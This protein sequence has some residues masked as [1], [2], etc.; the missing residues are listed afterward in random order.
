VARTRRIRGIDQLRSDWDELARQDAFHAI[1][2]DPARV[3]GGWDQDEF[4]AHGRAA[5]A[6]LYEI[7]DENDVKLGDSRA[8][9]FGCGAG[10]LSFALAER[11]AAVTGVD[12]SEGMLARARSVGIPSNCEL[13]LQTDSALPGIDRG[14]YDLVISLLVLQHMRPRVAR[15]YLRTLPDLLAPGGVLF[16]Q[17]PHGY[18]RTTDRDARSAGRAMARRLLPQSAIDLRRWLAL[19]RSAARRRRANVPTFELHRIRI[20]TVRRILGRAGLDA[21]VL[22]RDDPGT[23][24]P[25]S[26][27]WY[28]AQRAHA[29]VT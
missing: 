13:V 7:L 4:Y 22:T 1:L 25:L 26:S 5:V 6:R 24:A 15:A 3:D 10:R 19:R 12:V 29:D 18:S 20:S 28:V 2:S 23:A 16:V 21:V 27:A 9:D 17:I 8:L 11:F 14:A